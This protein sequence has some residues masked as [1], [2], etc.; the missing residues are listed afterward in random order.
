M[1]R[2]SNSELAYLAT[3]RLGRLATS[4]PDGALQNSP[5][6]LR[7]NPETDTLDITGFNL[8]TSQKY[9]NIAG[10]GR[11]A[12]VVDDLA[13]IE[14]WRVRCVEIRAEAEAVEVAGVPVILLHPRQ[15]ISFGLEE[16]V[17]AHELTVSNR[18]V[19]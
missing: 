18:H 17:E 16:D 8:A 11:A 19:D 5:V 14:P 1:S 9:R 4:K 12:L 2:F 15:V 6:G 7:H 10:N 3:Q 13:S